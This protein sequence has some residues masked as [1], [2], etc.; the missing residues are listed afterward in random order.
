MSTKP[1]IV[2]VSALLL[3]LSSVINT[4]LRAQPYEG[5]S[6][7]LTTGGDGGTVV[8]V[9]NLNDSG[10]GSLRQAILNLT[11]SPTSI[12]F[13]VGGKIC[14]MSEMR[15]AK[16]FVTIAGETAPPPG[17]TLE[18]AYSI[19]RGLSIKTTDVIVRHI[20]MRNSPLENLQIWGDARIIIDHC[21]LTWSGDGAVDWNSGYVT[22]SRNLIAGCVEGSKTHGTQVSVHHNFY[23]DNNRRQP[24]VFEPSGPAYD[25][26]NNYFRSWGNWG[27]QVVGA[28]ASCNII[29]NYY[30]PPAPGETW[31]SGIANQSAGPFYTAG[32]LASDPASGWDPNAVGTTSTPFEQPLVTTIPASDVPANV[33]ANVGAQPNDSTDLVWLNAAPGTYNS[34]P[35]VWTPPPNLC[36]SSGGG[37]GG[38]T[39]SETADFYVAQ[40]TGSDSNAGSSTA[41]F[42]TIGK[43]ISSATAGKKVL[44]WTG[45]YTEQLSFTLNAG[46]SASPITV[47]SDLAAGAVTVVSPGATTSTVYAT[48]GYIIL[49]GFTITSGKR[50]IEFAADAADGWTIKNCIVKG[51]SQDG[52]YL[53]YGDNNTIYNCLLYNNGGANNGIYVFG[54]ATGNTV[55]QCTVYGHKYGVQFATSASGS[56]TNSIVAKATV[57]GVWANGTTLTVTY[58][59]V[60]GNGT[61]YNGTSGGT[62]TISADPKFVSPADGDFQLLTGSLCIGTASDGGDMGYRYARY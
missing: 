5:Y 36:G 30:G 50:G 9:T 46:T 62:G 38:I 57:Y 49:D 28:G 33:L 58:S 14:V 25:I 39:W 19:D 10:P 35:T 34:R 24:R 37:G 8:F 52:I 55:K 26:R 17:I 44:V 15:I 47:K 59:D 61:N 42:K 40:A 56:I 6:A 22:I 13:T 48:K 1:R 31:V 43:G 45:S 11:G 60:W 2:L 32:N 16:P 23:T 3:L 20:R 18:T 21:S 51:N 54:T 29:N 4:A 53:R 7:A 27:T 41:P 12:Q